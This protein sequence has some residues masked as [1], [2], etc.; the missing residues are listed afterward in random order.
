MIKAIILPNVGA[1]KTISFS[2]TTED[3][4]L[5]TQFFVK[6]YFFCKI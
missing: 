3:C 2:L 1:D 4:N 6:K 5:N